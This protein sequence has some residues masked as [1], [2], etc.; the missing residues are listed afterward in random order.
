MKV[1]KEQLRKMENIRSGYGYKHPVFSYTEI[2][3]LFRFMKQFK[4][5]TLS[6]GG[7][8]FSYTK[9]KKWL[10]AEP[11]FKTKFRFRLGKTFVKE[12]DHGE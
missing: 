5:N 4:L 3:R 2:H 10:I 7:F 12:V 8:R 1:S 6:T 9:N 11:D